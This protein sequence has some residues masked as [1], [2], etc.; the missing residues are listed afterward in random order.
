[1]MRKNMK[2]VFFLIGIL[3]LA[4]LACGPN[5]SGVPEVTIP[6]GA[7]ETIQAAGQQAGGVAETAVAIAT[8]EG[9]VAIETLQA[10]GSA[11]LGALEE[12]FQSIQ[13]DENGNFS[14]T[15]TD[16]E[17]NEA[18][19]LGQ[20]SQGAAGNSPLKQPVVVF[21]GG[22]IVLTGNVTQP[23]EAQLTVVFRPSVANGVV[24][25]EVVSATLGTIQV[26]AAVLSTA[27]ATL[28]STLGQA[29]GNIPTGFTLQSVVM[30]EGTMTVSGTRN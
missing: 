2:P 21:T 12:K 28:N 16:T 13:T 24:Q 26:P 9:S 22:N 30:G 14:V 3:V 10:G 18:I 27:E 8:Q 11:G 15:V 6:A 25:F 7:V 1:M 23:I 19:Q 4:A 29:M 5:L 17:V 20:E